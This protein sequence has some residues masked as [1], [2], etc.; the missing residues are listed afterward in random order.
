MAA[1]MLAPVVSFDS[2][3]LS[4]KWLDALTEIR[5]ELQFQVPGRA[6]IRFSDPGYALLASNTVKLGTTVRISDPANSSLGLIDAEVTS[7]G[8]EQPVGQQPELVVVAHDKSHRLGRAT[9][10]KTYLMMS[11][12]DI[13]TQLAGD[14]GLAPAVDPTSV[15]FD[16]LL[17][18]DSGLG[19]LTELARRVGYDW[20][21]DS[22]T[23]HFKKPASGDTVNLSLSDDLQS[24]SVRASGHHPDEVEV[25]AW[26]RE[27]QQ[28]VSSTAKLS[29][30]DFSG[31]GVNADSDLARL[32][33]S[34]GSAFGGAAKLQT[35]ALS[36]LTNEEVEQ[37]SKAVLTHA[38][39]CAVQAQGVAFGNGHI[40]LG[41][42]ADVSHAGPL[43]GTY[44]ITRVEHVFRPRAGFVTRFSSGDRWPTSIVDAIG[45]AR[46]H[47]AVV[48][49]H[50]GLVVG[51]VTNIKD[52]NGA[53]RVKV[54]YPGLSD[55][56]ESDW[57]RVVAVGGG[58]D[59]GTAFVPEVNDEVLVGFE[60]ADPRQP[61]VIGGLYSSKRKI[62]SPNID[63]GTG[64]VQSRGMTSRLGHFIGML[65]GTQPAQQAIEL[66]LA[67]GDS[68]TQNIIHLGQDKLSITI[69]EGLP[70]EINAGNSSLKFDQEGGL[71]ITAPKVSITAEQQF[72]VSAAQVS[73]NGE[74][75]LSLQGNGAT[76]LSGSTLQL[77][78]EGPL[79]A[80]G[81]PIMLN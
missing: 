69:G 15:S 18:A 40:K 42:T 2:R 26:D 60:T 28:A 32:V 41:A 80:S 81:Q 56:I 54:K 49:S 21:V 47:R 77:S 51:V 14:V 30:K 27:N 67:K 75:Q 71:S 78:A 72:S 23:L 10:V 37:L 61:V 6:T 8:A 7:I 36:G 73:I 13:V 66:S 74:S 63:D 16:N 20:W 53:G 59:R 70:V 34:P 68:G 17:Q 50:L 44:P 3:N 52:P 1:I 76:S 11:Y 38:A 5:I 35:S 64:M 79:A 48:A 22:Q 4:A 25:N 43:N 29:A 9:N 24:F 57:A 46:S 55:T 33:S 65:D 12:S 62:P 31:S 45:V 19:L 39:S 58:A